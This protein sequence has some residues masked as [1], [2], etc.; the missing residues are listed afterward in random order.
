MSCGRWFL[1]LRRQLL[2]LEM[3]V[4]EFGNVGEGLP[5]LGRIDVE[6]VLGMRLPLI[7]VE[8]GDHAC[9]AQFAM[10]PNRVAEKQVTGAGGQD[11]GREAL[12]VA[13]D[14]R[15]VGILQALS[16][17]IKPGRTAEPAV[18]GD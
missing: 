4:E 17:R 11:R 16:V 18:P 3:P 14:R 10:R 8:V 5:G 13:V 15:D 7:D 6:L 9:A 12:E 2:F 1:S